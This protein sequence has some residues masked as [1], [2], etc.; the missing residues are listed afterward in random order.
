MTTYQVVCATKQH[1]HRHIVSVGTGP[2]SARASEVWTV[3]QV[4]AKLA[5]GDRFYTTDSRGRQADVEP[6]TCHQTGCNGFQTVR[7]KPDASTSNNLDAIR[8]CNP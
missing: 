5:A 7:T 2:E 8:N 1:A 3:A 4:R 6:Y